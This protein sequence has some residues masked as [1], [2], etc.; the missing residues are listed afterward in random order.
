MAPSFGHIE[1][2]KKE[3]G[4]PRRRAQGRLPV[5][6]TTIRN[7]IEQTMA[8]N[9]FFTLGMKMELCPVLDKDMS[10]LNLEENTKSVTQDSNISI[11]ESTKASGMRE[12]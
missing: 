1:A 4:Y 8:L 5:E 3:I 11:T 10:T 2:L 7:A 6:L 9:N 12:E